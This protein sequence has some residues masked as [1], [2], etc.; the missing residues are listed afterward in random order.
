MP[1][2]PKPLHA[3]GDRLPTPWVDDDVWITELRKELLPELHPIMPRVLVRSLPGGKTPRNNPQL[4]YTAPGDPHIYVNSFS[5]VYKAAR[6]G[7][8][9]AR[10]ELAAVLVHEHTHINGKDEP[11][12]YGAQLDTLS[13]LRASEPAIRRAVMARDKTAA[14]K[15]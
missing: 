11:E 12:A 5:D 1:N 2:E 9:D 4:A 13:R 7:D 3:P 15:R 10:K 6:A 8:E 14:S